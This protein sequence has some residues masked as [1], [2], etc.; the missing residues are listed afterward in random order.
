[1]SNKVMPVS[2]GVVP[3]LV[4]RGAS[5]AIAFYTEAFGAKELFRMPGPGDLLMHA[6]IIVK[7]SSI[8]LC[9]EMPEC[10]HG[11]VK[12]PATLG[13][14]TFNIHLNVDDV[15]AVYAQAVEAGAEASMPPQDM[16]WGDRYG[17]IVDPFGHVWSIAT[18]VED[19]TPEQMTER[20]ASMFAPQP[21]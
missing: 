3:H 7:G 21:A 11:R 17:Q 12:S 6:Q 18:H 2:Q 8:Y 15:D 14:T 13:G 19:V 9:D 16:F 20:M 1:M 5:E 4:I 10:E